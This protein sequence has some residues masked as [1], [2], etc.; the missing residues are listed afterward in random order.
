[1]PKA[2]VIKYG[3]WVVKDRDQYIGFKQLVINVLLDHSGEVLLKGHMHSQRASSIV[4]T[5]SQGA[6]CT[7]EGT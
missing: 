5:T 1:M 2:V 3:R 4:R 7:I 6:V